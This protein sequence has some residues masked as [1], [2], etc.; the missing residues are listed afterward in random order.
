MTTKIELSFKQA[1][2]NNSTPVH[3]SVFQRKQTKLRFR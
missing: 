2:K 1:Y 3:S